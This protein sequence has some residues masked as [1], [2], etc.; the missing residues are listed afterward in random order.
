MLFYAL[1]ATVADGDE[2]LVPD[3]GFP[4]YASITRFAGGTPVSYEVSARSAFALDPESIAARMTQR[5][6]VIVVNAPHNPTG[7]SADERALQLIAELAAEHDVFVIADEVYDSCVYD[8]DRA[9]SIAA[10]PDVRELVVVVNS[11]SKTYAMTGWRLGF[12]IV[13]PRARERFTTLA[14]NG[15]SCVPPFVQRAGIAAIE[16]PQTDRHRMVDEFRRRRDWLVAQLNAVP[17][18]TC[19]TPAGAFYVFPDVRGVLRASGLTTQELADRLLGRYAVAALPGT[20]F[21]RGGDGHLRFSFATSMDTLEFAVEGVRR[22]FA[23]AIA[24]RLT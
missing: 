21:G 17:G 1:A 15:H 10:I 5:T 22:C 13:P 23:D 19:H 3:P 6:R 20:A 12:G 16:G 7:G 4:A 8:R 2:V 14:V 9:P 24:G 18:V 11:F